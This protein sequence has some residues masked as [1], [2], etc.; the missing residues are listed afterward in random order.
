MEA[1]QAGRA[2]VDRSVALP[3]AL[4]DK[5]PD[6]LRRVPRDVVSVI[7][8][9]VDPR[10]G[11]RLARLLDLPWQQQAIL[12][13]P[14]ERDGAWRAVRRFLNGSLGQIADQTV[15]GR[16][17]C[18]RAEFPA[19]P[20]PAAPA[21]ALPRSAPAAPRDRP[22]SVSGRGALGASGGKACRRR[23]ARPSDTAATCHSK[24]C[25]EPAQPW[26]RRGRGTPSPKPRADHA[27][28]PRPRR[29]RGARRG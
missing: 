4:P 27:T 22:C 13:P 25:P 17:R 7:F 14:D 23:E 20:S 16:R 29:L 28:C 11:E 24:S 1:S 12:A 6:L 15:E 18:E 10:I 21:R 8:N 19:G 3:D 2:T 26:L 9:P 5:A